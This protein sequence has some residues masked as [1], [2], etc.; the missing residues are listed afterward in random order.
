MKQHIKSLPHHPKRVII[1]SLVVALIIGIF[2]YKEINK[3]VPL[4]DITSGNTSITTAGGSSTTQDLSLGFLVGGRISSVSVKAGDK[5]KKGA[6][7]ATLD[8]ENTVG[9]LAQAQAAYE[10][11]KANYDKIINGATSTSIDVARTAVNAAQVNLDE[12][13]KQQEILVANAY[14]ALLNSSPAAINVGDY[15]GY[16][17]PTVTGAYTCANQGSYDLKTYS[18]TGGV[19]VSYTGLET[20]SF[21]LTDI[22]RPLGNCGL[23]LSFDKTKVLQ[24]DAE[25]SVNIPNKNAPN[26]NA[27]NDAYQLSLKTKD[28]AIAGAQAALDQANASLTALVTAARPEDVAAAQAQVDNAQGA[29]QIAQA[30]YNNTIITAPADGTVDSVAITPGQIATPNSPAIDFTSDPINNN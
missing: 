11:A 23:F 6:V 29:V 21:L 2:G 4:P 10:T 19:S 15:N 9:A 27:N 1:I 26:Y 16:D 12:T 17:A 20:G 14:N 30:A 8:A 24:G 5:V 3:K 22:P 25:F 13:T 7:L 28:Q 18:S